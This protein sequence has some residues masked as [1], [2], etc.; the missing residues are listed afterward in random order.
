[1]FHCLMIKEMSDNIVHNDKHECIV[2]Y[3]IVYKTASGRLEHLIIVA[4]DLVMGWH[5]DFQN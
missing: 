5:Q 3:I 4:S 1:M 2:Y